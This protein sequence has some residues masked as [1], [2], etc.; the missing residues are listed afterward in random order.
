[1]RERR[2]PA[3]LRHHALLGVDEQHRE[4][5]GRRRRDHV[6]RVLLVARCVGDD[7]LAQCRREIP[8]RDV[9]RDALLTL[10]DEA[11]GQQRQVEHLTTTLRR[12]LDRGELVGQYR[13]GVVEQAAD[14]RAL[15][16]V[17][18]ARGQ[19]TQHAV[20]EDGWIVDDGH[21]K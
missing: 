13:L 11:V 10:G 4:M 8:V 20:I 6:P 3:R 19:E 1:M 7:E 2:V 21:Q 14:Q 15:A 5:R 12:A 9:D 17:D 16:V 18:T